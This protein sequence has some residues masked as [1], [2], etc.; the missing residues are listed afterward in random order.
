MKDRSSEEWLCSQPFN[1]SV[2]VN[3]TVTVYVTL[4]VNV[5]VPQ[6]RM[7]YKVTVLLLN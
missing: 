4:N 3:I 6:L 5:T 1:E 7:L 2:T